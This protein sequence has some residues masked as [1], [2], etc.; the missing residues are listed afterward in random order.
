MSECMILGVLTIKILNK[1][2]VLVGWIETLCR[3]MSFHQVLIGLK[4]GI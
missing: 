1:S 3:H 2:L 4:A